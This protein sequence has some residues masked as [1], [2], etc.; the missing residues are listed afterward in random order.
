MPSMMRP[1]SVWG[2]PGTESASISGCFIHPKVWSTSVWVCP[3]ARACVCGGGGGA[4]EN[5]HDGRLGSTPNT[6]TCKPTPEEAQA[7]VATHE[8]GRAGF[9]THEKG[10]AG[11][12]GWVGLVAHD[13]VGVHD[14]RR[15]GVV[16]MRVGGPST[17]PH[18]GVTAGSNPPAADPR[19]IHDRFVWP[20]RCG[21]G[22]YLGGDAL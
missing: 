2:R 19:N 13:D 9:E 17:R 21:M 14:Y 18:G 8:E 12:E 11:F 1:R 10:Q 15:R 3:T 22:Q 6:H 4:S 16:L 5:R 7:G 20:V